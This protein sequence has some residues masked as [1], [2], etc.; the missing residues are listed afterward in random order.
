M[1]I[2]EALLSS[3]T[4][5]VYQYGNAVGALVATF[6]LGFVLIAVPSI[7]VPAFKSPLRALTKLRTTHIIG[8]S[9]IVAITV[10]YYVESIMY[11][12]LA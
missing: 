4:T 10:L 12:I 8:I 3:Y 6:L 5:N 9:I 7:F 11:S 1:L 2:F